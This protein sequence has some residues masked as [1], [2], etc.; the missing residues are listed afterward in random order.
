MTFQGDRGNEL[1]GFLLVY[2]LASL[3]AQHDSTWLLKFL[4]SNAGAMTSIT[5]EGLHQPRNFTQKTSSRFCLL[6]RWTEEVTPTSKPVSCK[7]LG[8]SNRSGLI[9]L[10]AVVMFP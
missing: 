3:E 7:R 10:L 1:E 2:R 4:V 8:L 6:P 5:L 9:L